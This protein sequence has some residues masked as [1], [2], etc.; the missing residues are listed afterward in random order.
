[1]EK[2]NG[3]NSRIPYTPYSFSVRIRVR[4]MIRIR[5][6][7]RIWVRIKVRVRD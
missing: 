7:V 3:L 5:I 2:E 6:M 1:M 4:N